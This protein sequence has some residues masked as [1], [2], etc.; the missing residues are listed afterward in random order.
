M[1]LKLTRYPAPILKQRLRAVETEEDWAIVREAIE[2]MLD[3]MKKNGGI[4][5]A[6]NQAGLGLRFFVTNLL[7]D[8]RVCV[9]P[10]FSATDG[11]RFIHTEGCLSLPVAQYKISRLPK[12]DFYFLDENG[13]DGTMEV[14]DLK[15]AMVQHEIDHLNGR[16]IKR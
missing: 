11:K 1:E 12:G 16:L 6:A 4:G 7:G 3:I 15:A 13:V 5:L 9:N 2:P 10:D 14:K 8:F